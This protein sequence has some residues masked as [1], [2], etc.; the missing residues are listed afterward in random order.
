MFSPTIPP[1]T[2]IDSL[3]T[4]AAKYPLGFFIGS[5]LIHDPRRGS[6]ISTLE[7]VLLPSNPPRTYLGRRRRLQWRHK[8]AQIK[9]SKSNWM[10]EKEGGYGE[11]KNALRLKYQKFNWMWFNM[12]AWRP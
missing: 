8:C 11:D 9:I 7:T 10:W 5:P 2:K 6:N 4:P 12:C 3:M 1:I